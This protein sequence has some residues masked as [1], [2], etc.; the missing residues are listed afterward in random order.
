[1]AIQDDDTAKI[2]LAKVELE[3]ILARQVTSLD[4]SDLIK[5]NLKGCTACE[6][7]NKE[8]D[9]YKSQYMLGKIK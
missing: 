9:Y 1:M 7:Y 3:K 5:A 8:C 4:F 6:G 2:C